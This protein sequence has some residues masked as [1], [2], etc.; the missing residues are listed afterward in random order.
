MESL[1]LNTK[2]D[3]LGAPGVSCVIQ[4]LPYETKTKFS[5]T[6]EAMST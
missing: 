3:Q 5:I 6:V 4:L 2:V 1:L